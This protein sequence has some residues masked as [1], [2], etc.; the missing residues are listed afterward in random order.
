M[1]GPIFDARSQWNVGKRR[2]KDLDGA[3]QGARH[4]RRHRRKGIALHMRRNARN[5]RDS[6]V[7]IVHIEFISAKNKRLKPLSVPIGSKYRL[8]KLLGAMRHIN[9]CRMLECIGAAL[10]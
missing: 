2:K 10:N 4:M 6:F 7:W 1:I 3:I 8:I 5:A 9:Q